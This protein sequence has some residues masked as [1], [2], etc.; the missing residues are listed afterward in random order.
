[1]LTKFF[2]ICINSGTFPTKLKSAEVHPIYKKGDKTLT[3]NHRPISIL[4]PFS[5]ILER[6]IHTKLTNFITKFNILH[7]F[8]FDFRTNSSTEMALTQ[9]VEE[10]SEN[11]EKGETTCSVFLDLAT[12]FDTVDHQIL[13]NKLY[14]YGVRGLPAKLIQDY[15]TNRTQITKVNNINSDIEYITCGV[16]QG[17]ILGPLLFNLYINDIINSSN[18]KIK[19]FAD[20]ACLVYSCKDAK[21]LEKRVNLELIKVN[22]WRKLNKL[23]VNFSKSNYI[24]FTNKQNNY[25]YTINMDGHRLERTEEMKYLGVILDHKL[26]WSKHVNYII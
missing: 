6:H 8:Q 2:N 1:M 14:K 18:F 15:L 9:I 10:I 3:T 22:I 23:S 16:P 4:S 19:L 24:I 11:I 20:D 7:P 25:N 13:L 26:S 12:A 17:S 5:K 21:Q